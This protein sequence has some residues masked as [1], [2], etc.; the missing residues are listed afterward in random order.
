MS[1]E[2]GSPAMPKW[3]GVVGL[4]IAPTTIITSLCYFYGYVATRT[5]FSYF[6][7]DT[8]A[9]GFTT[10]DY[11]VKSLPALYVPLVV[12]LFAWVAM[13]WAADYLRRLVQSGRRPRLLRGVAWVSIALG[14]VGVAIAIVGLTKPDWAPIQ[15]DVATPVALGLGAALLMV[16]L[17][18]LGGT[19]TSDAP[20][21]FAAAERGSLVV[22]A[23]AIVVALFWVADIFATFRGHDLAINTNAGLWSRENVVV[24]DVDAKQDVPLLL[25]NQIKVSWAPQGAD[26]SAKSA[27][28]RYECFRSLAVHNDRWVLVPARWAPAAGFAVIV[29]ADASHVISLKRIEHIADSAA[30][31]NTDAGWECPEVGIDTQ[32]K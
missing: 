27:F 8:D 3:I 30:A 9:I 24:L 15:A 12:G 6:G 16:G 20:R 32:G 23:G 17:W 19:R 7:I 1:E 28:L 4:F 21:P 5:Y 13:L 14:V 29:N 26:P 18:L 11:V 2:E 31:K 25:G 10:T 22:A